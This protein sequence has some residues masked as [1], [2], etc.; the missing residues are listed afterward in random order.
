MPEPDLTSLELDRL[1]ALVANHERQSATG[2]PLYKRAIDELERR[3]SSGLDVDTSFGVIR[4]AARERRFVSYK[5]LADASGVSW[6][7]VRRS[8]GSHMWLLVKRGHARGWPMLSAVVVNK[9][10]VATGRMEPETLKGFVA[11]ARE[12]GHDVADSER[13]SFLHAQQQAVFA[14]AEASPQPAET[15]DAAGPA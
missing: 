7:K 12:L 15:A 3:E 8:I 5:D 1:R 6:S 2:A 9:P 10:N 11:A 14:W 13:E 4:D